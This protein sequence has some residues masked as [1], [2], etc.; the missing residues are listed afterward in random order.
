MHAA[1]MSFDLHVPESRS[2]KAKRPVIRPIVDGMRHRFRISVA[3]VD[4]QD[5]WQRAT[6]A[7]AVVAESDGRVRELL[8]AAERFVA[9]GA[10]RRA[11]GHARPGGS[12]WRTRSGA[13]RFGPS[14][15]THG[16]RQRG[17]ARGRRRRARAPERPAP[18]SRHRHRRRR[19][20]RPPPRDRL[21]LRARA[22]REQPKR[23][24]RRGARPVAE[25]DVDATDATDAQAEF[26]TQT[27]RRC[28]PRRRICA[29]RSGARSA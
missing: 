12:R 15:S 2:L 14:L 21:L 26:K 25:P 10:R 16:A 6:I 19:Q 27:K 13:A 23:S 5:Q 7:V 22:G 3:E 28:A 8:D 20:R 18:R 11:A 29:P 17:R 4:H 9:G 1:A 24:R